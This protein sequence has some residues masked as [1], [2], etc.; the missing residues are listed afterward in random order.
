MPLPPAAELIAGLEVVALP[1]RRRFRG[2]TVRETALLRGPEGWTEFAAFP[3]YDDPEAARWLAAAI[4]YGWQPTPPALRDRIPVNAT[5]P[6]VA[7]EDVAGVLALY[8]GC[9]TAKVKV[10]E[11]GGV[12]AEDIDRVA[13]VREVLGPEGRIRL[14]ANGA[15]NVDE[16]ERALHELVRFDLE[17]LEQPCATA[18]ELAELARRTKYLDVPIAVDEG[19]RKS[20][21]PAAA[22]AS[23]PPR[24]VLVVK[25]APL[26]GVRAGLR[27]A[28]AATGPV[29][30]SS[31]LESSVGLA[32]GAALAAALPDLPY[33][34]GLGTGAL[35][36]ADVTA[37]PLVPVGGSIPVG[38][39]E[40]DADLLARH[41]ADADR[42][43]WWAARIE[44][45]R[46]LLEAQRPD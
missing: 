46:A 35:L 29:V 33:D 42:R 45:C 5:V 4:E 8:P 3:E 2:I 32:M 21:D 24:A 44:R 17:Y 13:A 7:A 18:E 15:W 37:S 38:R 16:A 31:A 19:V 11:P 14:D 9:R 22:V 12:L 43:A 27:L 30:V 1:L 23:A 25:A 10:A 28:A 36:A 20:G 39:V 40:P 34:C 26:G 6:A 41:R